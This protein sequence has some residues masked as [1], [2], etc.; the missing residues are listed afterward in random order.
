MLLWRLLSD[1]VISIKFLVV[2][3]SELSCTRIITVFLFF[4]FLTNLSH[5]YLKRFAGYNWMLN[6]LV[7]KFLIPIWIGIIQMVNLESNFH[8]AIKQIINY[9]IFD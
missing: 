7:G 9:N 6:N 5:A 4:S 2:D 3:V 1:Y 8:I